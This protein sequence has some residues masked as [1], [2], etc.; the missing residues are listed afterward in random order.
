MQRNIITLS[1]L[2]LELLLFAQGRFFRPT[3][4]SKDRFELPKRDELRLEFTRR[5]LKKSGALKTQ[6]NLFK[7]A[8]IRRNAECPNPTDVKTITNDKVSL[9]LSSIKTIISILSEP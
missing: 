5:D 2:V 4:D 9:K 8:R 3:F 1:F 7:N 6:I